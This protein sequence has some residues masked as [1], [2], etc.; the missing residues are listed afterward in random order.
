MDRDDIVASIE[1]DEATVDVVRR[2]IGPDIALLIDYNQSLSMPEAIR[3]IERLTLY[4]P[5]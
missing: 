5:H 4:D 3:R 1:S 2:S